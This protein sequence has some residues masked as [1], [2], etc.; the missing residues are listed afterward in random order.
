MTVLQLLS[1]ISVVNVS[2]KS[3]YKS[4]FNDYLETKYLRNTNTIRT[5]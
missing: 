4:S 5:D 3:R 2:L 1:R